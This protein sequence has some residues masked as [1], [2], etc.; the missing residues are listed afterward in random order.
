M[1]KI[2]SITSYP[3]ENEM[4]YQSYFEKYEYP[5]HIF[6]KHAIEAIV[7]G[8]HVL[9]TAP[10][11]SGKTLPGDF[12]I[13][14]FH[15]KGK[16]VIYTTP[17][18]ALSNQ[19]FY[20]FT[21]KYKN[22]SIG[23][24]TG[25]IKTNPDADI[26]IMTTEILLNKLF[27]IKSNTLEPQSSISFEMD[28]ENEL[29][30]VVYDEI[31][32]INDAARGHV[33]EQS[34]MMLPKHI[35]IIG[36]SAT[37]DNPEKFALWLEN[38][39]EFTTNPEKI[40]YLA[41]KLDRA[42][43]LTHYGF[44]TTTSGIF[45]AVK[46]KSIQEE[47]KTIINKPFLLQDHKGNF[48]ESQY[49]KM[50]KNLKLFEKYDVRVRRQHVLNELTKHL[51]EKEMLPALCYVFSR[52]Q[53]EICAKEITTNLLEFDSKVPYI[54]DR[55]CEH[56]IRKL[57]NYQEY[58][59]LPE[60]INMVTLLR[61]GIAIHHSGVT[62]ILREMVE[63]LFAK[64]Y[65][66]LLFCTETMSV[67][68]NMPVKTSI[69]TDVTKFDG[70]ISRMLYSH[71]YTQ[72]AGRAGRLGLDKVGH[73][74]HLNNLFR[75]VDMVNYKAMMS[76]KPP[77]LK[78]KFKI[79]YNLL[80][81]LIDIGDNNFIN[82][83]RKSMVKDDLDVTLKD[84]Y[85]KI[86]NEQMALDNLELTFKNTRTPIEIVNQY[87][88]LLNKRH[89]CVNKKRK[90]IEK[91][92]ENIKDNYVNIEF[93]KIKVDKF[94]KTLQV[95]DDLQTEYNRVEKFI[96]INV[97]KIINVLYEDG[98]VQKHFIN[99]DNINNINN[100]NICENNSLFLTLKGKFACQLRETHC[101]IFS[102]L[103][104]ENMFDNLNAIQIVM[105]FSCL[106]NIVVKDEL[107]D[108]IPKIEDNTTKEILFKV[109]NMYD[110]CLEKETQ[111]NINSGLDYTF[112]FDLLNYVEKWCYSENITDCKQILYELEN[113]KGIFL[114]EFVKAILKITNIC[115]ELEKLSEMTGNMSL[116]SKLK[117]IP[118]MLLKYVVT[119][120]S[121]Y[122]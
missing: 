59:N 95:V 118:N 101:L 52:K 87:L 32:M 37:L 86:S 77:T 79:S 34:I 70:E 120:Q 39:G 73:V 116:L 60:Y 114:G 66:K 12:S 121:L 106:T 1:V 51:V 8:N 54:V 64:G 45:K 44:I 56:I 78:S 14:Y 23:L 115:N 5:L 15:S 92:I 110:K 100:A 117:D 119:N 49:S 67:G 68:I 93:D 98:F 42:V 105:L 83:A 31:H 99:E 107:K 29:G 7:E 48:D 88:D 74:I 57:P 55:E 41:S 111:L 17:I 38:K 58:L 36:L 62:P 102:Q 47:I 80:L 20:D 2:C 108:Y 103:F 72:A 61:K 122:V 4:T 24:I 10:T 81:N 71:E 75:N 21:N 40:V 76:G 30:C 28:I 19:K 35:Q 9:V 113:D 85:Y 89:C 50:N 33:W 82:F 26:L 65:I 112:H 6:Q 96:D 25:D 18:K 43:P 11:G 27:Q 16:K 104:E 109:R 3:K 13:D 63:L 46:D 90:E 69:F 22:I 84:I 53:L 97:N 91:Q 94:N